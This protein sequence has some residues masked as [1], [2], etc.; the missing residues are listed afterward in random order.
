MVLRPFFPHT[1][2]KYEIEC[3]VRTRLAEFPYDR[4][5]AF[6]YAKIWAFQRNPAF[7]NFD[8][9]GGDCTNFASQCIYAGCKVMNYT[10][11]FGWYYKSSSD[12]TPSWSGVQYLYNFLTT[13]KGTGPYAEVTDTDS[14]EIGDILQLGDE[15]EHFYH[16]PIV[17]GKTDEDIFVAAHTYDSYMR[18]LSSYIYKKIRCLHILGYRKRVPD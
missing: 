16:S 18:P 14:L 15:L 12:R 4:K 8:K 9:M 7:I 17:V 6:E 2:Y 5:N 1:I 13:N 11:V 10:P 3:G